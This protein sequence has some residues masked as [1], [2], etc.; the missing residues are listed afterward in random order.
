MSIDYIATPALILN[1][2][3]LSRNADRMSKR[4]ADMGVRLRPHMK[5]AKSADVAR[6]ATKDHFGGV[7]VSTVAEAR[8]MAEKGIKDI[9]YAVGLSPGKVAPLAEIQASHD[10]VI[11]VL[12]DNV[13]ALNAVATE[14]QRLETSFPVLVEVDCGGGR[15]GL[16]AD[17]PD[18][19][20]VV[21]AIVAAPVLEF[22]GIMTHAGQSYG[23]NSTEEMAD[24]AEVERAT[25][26]EVGQMLADQ[27]FDCK[28]LTTG[29]TPT[30]AHARSMEGITEARPG[31]YM[32][33][34]VMQAH[35]GW[36]TTDDIAVSVLATVIGHRKD[37][38]QL[39]IDAGGLALSKDRGME[40]RDPNIGLGVVCNTQTQPI[41]GLYV[42]D[43]HQEH[44]IVKAAEGSIIPWDDMPVGS[45]VRV[46]PVHAC[47]TAAAHD[48]YNVVDEDSDGNE[49]F[50]SL[51]IWQRQNGWY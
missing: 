3:R 6:L 44:G 40:S 48:Y 16:V 24:V 47:M 37:L 9:F 22:A 38:D 8:Y 12:T 23:C 5:T 28:T 31:V 27:G 33:S 2:S 50:S 36:G 15:A 45:R 19:I 11:T 43:S 46:L 20:D 34:D 41:K 30:A 25:L 39:L 7:T 49:D 18:L 51:T 10:A 32:F 17:D 26:V 14:A 21:K 35:F 13:D 29:S 4:L 1:R 42:A